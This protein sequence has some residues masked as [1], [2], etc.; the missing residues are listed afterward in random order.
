MPRVWTVAVTV[1]SLVAGAILFARFGPFMPFLE[2]AQPHAHG[3]DDLVIRIDVSPGMGSTE[4]FFSEP[5]D[6]VVT[7]DGTAYTPGEGP[8]TGI[9]AP[10]VSHD[11][12]EGR[13]LNLLKRAHHDGLLADHP[14]YDAPADVYD[15]STTDV[16]LA[17]DHGRWTHRAYALGA[18]GWG[19]SDRDRLFDFVSD[20]LA[21]GGGRPSPMAGPDALRVMTEQGVAPDGA[22]GVATWPH[23]ASV[24]PA[25]I[26]D[27]MVVHDP[28]VVRALTTAPEQYYRQGGRTY[29]VAAAVPLPGDW[30]GG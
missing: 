12:G 6:L 27:C 11:L 20:A 7:G 25:E 1:L 29:S 23:D 14:T 18:R 24:S 3:H 10:V 16:L 5:P 15:G 22:G 9:V 13:L 8:R 30:C 17:T 26:G 19:F 2:P 28:A 21:E 4:S